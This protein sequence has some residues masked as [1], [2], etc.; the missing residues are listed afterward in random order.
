MRTGQ[1]S[2]WD[3]LWETINR[4]EKEKAEIEKEISGRAKTMIIG[5]HS[6]DGVSETYIEPGIYK[7]I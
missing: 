4:E 5:M 6:D 7:V 1:L 3:S 2:G